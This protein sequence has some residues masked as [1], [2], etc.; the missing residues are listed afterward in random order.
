MDWK[1][2]ACLE[3][4][5]QVLE[6]TGNGKSW[7]G[8]GRIAKEFIRLKT[9]LIE[10]LD[11]LTGRVVQPLRHSSPAAKLRCFQR[12]LTDLGLTKLAPDITAEEVDLWKV[13]DGSPFQK[14]S[15]SAAGTKLSRAL[16]ACLR[17]DPWRCTERDAS[18]HTTRISDAYQ[19][20]MGGT[21]VLSANPLDIL[22]SSECC[23][24]TTCHNLRGGQHKAG[25]LQYLLDGHSAIAYLY[26]EE[27]EYFKFGNMPYKIWRQLVHFDKERRSAAFMRQYG[28][29]TLAAKEHQP[30]R[31][32]SARALYKL[33]GL[34]GAVRWS[35]PKKRV[36]NTHPVAKGAAIVYLDDYAANNGNWIRLRDG[37]F[38]KLHAAA[39]IPCPGCGARNLDS[40]GNHRCSV[41]RS[42]VNCAGC[43]RLLNIARDRVH[44]A[45]D[46]RQFCGECFNKLYFVCSQC[47]APRDVTDKVRAIAGSSEECS[48]CKPCANA[49]AATCADCRRHALIGAIIR[50]DPRGG[51]HC[52]VCELARARKEAAEKKIRRREGLGDAPPLLSPWNDWITPTFFEVYKWSS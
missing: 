49:C 29:M 18:A 2:E 39:A 51:R 34:T 43:D 22:M 7:K 16:S 52:V 32:M 23:S 17:G 28:G 48:L 44:P 25:P 38:P 35:A 19:A 31:A 10:A 9:P 26:R 46:R 4:C 15:K 47:S 36:G 12:A 14:R 50:I 41:C 42:H 8:F 33:L 27:A 21:L 3:A 45:P 5:P 11:P 20:H 6:A 1:I 13:G 24:Y 30:L 40:S 37:E